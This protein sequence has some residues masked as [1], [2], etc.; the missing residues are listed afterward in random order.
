MSISHEPDLGLWELCVLSGFLEMIGDV[1]TL[2][3]WG[4]H[5][6]SMCIP[7]VWSKSK[8]VSFSRVCSAVSYSMNHLGWV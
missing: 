8:G 7:V 5:Y 4:L 1:C 2:R 3:L 6:V